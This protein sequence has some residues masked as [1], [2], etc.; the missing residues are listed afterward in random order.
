[1]VT[2]LDMPSG[3]GEEYYLEPGKLV[4]GNPRQTLWLQYTDASKQFFAGAWRSEPGKW[5]ILYTE[6]EYCQVLEGTSIIESVDGEAFTV[7]A[8]DCFV[9]PKGFAGTWE[10]VHTTTKRFVIYEES[11]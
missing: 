8:G 3:P 6:E 7:T 4:I 11:A 9:I 5:K 1:M 10:V 2:K